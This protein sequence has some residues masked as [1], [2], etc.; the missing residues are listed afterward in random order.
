MNNIG[1]KKMWNIITGLILFFII[2]FMI[3]SLC[4]V[5]NFN[6]REKKLYEEIL[7]DYKEL[8]DM[9]YEITDNIKKG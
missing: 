5:I 8:N 3:V 1:D 9:L 6:I 2:M 7:K 4:I